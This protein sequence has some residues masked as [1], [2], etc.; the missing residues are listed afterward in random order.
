MSFEIRPEVK[1]TQV[2]KLVADTVDFLLKKIA[3]VGPCYIHH[4]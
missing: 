4:T 2:A 1:I 3:S